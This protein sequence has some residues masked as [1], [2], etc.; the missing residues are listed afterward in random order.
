VGFYT[1]GRDCRECNVALARI[2]L[3][4]AY[5]LLL[6]LLVIYTLMV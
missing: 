6:I 1:N 3:P 5:G 2:L 4:I